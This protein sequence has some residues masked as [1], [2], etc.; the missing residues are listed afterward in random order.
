MEVVLKSPIIHNYE[1]FKAFA[2]K[3]EL[4]VGYQKMPVVYP[5]IVT[6]SIETVHVSG[7][8]HYLCEYVYLADFIEVMATINQ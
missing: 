5:C 3:E 6:C 8:M 7:Y 1:E 2:E 4:G